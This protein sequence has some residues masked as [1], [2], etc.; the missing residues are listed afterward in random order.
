MITASESVAVDLSCLPADFS[1]YIS[2]HW[3]IDYLVFE[4]LQIPN[5]NSYSFSWQ[6]YVRQMHSCLEEQ[7]AFTVLWV[8]K[9]WLDL[10]WKRY[11][12]LSIVLPLLF[13]NKVVKHFSI[14][15]EYFACQLVFWGLLKCWLIVS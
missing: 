5:F 3:V 12:A 10:L 15:L 1:K 7:T 13:N 14:L 6:T 4:P 2:K 11:N 9:W 8:I